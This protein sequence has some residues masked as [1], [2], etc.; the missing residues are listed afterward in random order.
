MVPAR[1]H[2]RI[3]RDQRQEHSSVVAGA[4]ARVSA[5]VSVVTGVRMA[6]EPGRGRSAVPVRTAMLGS[7]LAVAALIA[8]VTV[9]ASLDRMLGDPRIAGYSWDAEVASDPGELPRVARAV[10]TVPGVQRTWRANAFQMANLEGSATD[11]ITAENKS[12]TVI[13]EGRAPADDDEVALSATALRV[14]HRRIGDRVSIASLTRDNEPDP[15]AKPRLFTIVG[16]FV[17]A[18]VAFESDRVGEA[19]SLT[20]EG[21]RSLAPFEWSGVYIEADP[22]ADLARL[23]ADLRRAAGPT[24]VVFSREEVGSVSNF[25]RIAELPLALGILLAFIAAAV[26]T[27]ALYTTVRRRRR[28]L[29][30]LKT[31]GFLGK[32]VR[33]T[34]A[35]EATSFIALA[36]TLGIPTGVIV[37]RWA[38]RL[39]IERLGLLPIAVVPVL[40]TMLVVP[41]ALAVANIVAALPAHSAARTQP[42]LVLRSE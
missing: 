19:L 39:Y 35:W 26:V 32:Q 11:V 9:G 25:R 20:P 36:V 16:Q 7:A 2:V 40:M 17:Y 1:R 34:V 37:G 23:I 24:A 3:R 29:A 4:L 41:I 22:D 31:L 15:S 33:A 42:A 6:F 14:R 38:W 21:L 5:P 13:S 30:I 28:D 18:H 8:S 12:A 27:H 10:A